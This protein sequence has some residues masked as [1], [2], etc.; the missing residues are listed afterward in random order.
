M[1]MNIQEQINNFG[2]TPAQLLK[3]PHPKRGPPNLNAISIFKN[4]TQLQV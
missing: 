1:L 3:K 2:Q 4:P